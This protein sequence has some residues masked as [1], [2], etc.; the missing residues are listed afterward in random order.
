MLRGT[1]TLRGGNR[2]INNDM[3][4]HQ[5]RG[6]SAHTIC[7]L[8]LAELLW[9]ELI[10]ITEEQLQLRHLVEPT[11]LLALDEQLQG[12]EVIVLGQQ[13]LDHLHG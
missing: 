3:E 5:I 11:R 10:H 2:P 4:S 8:V 1:Q 7:V 6:S 12:C 13:E 9:G